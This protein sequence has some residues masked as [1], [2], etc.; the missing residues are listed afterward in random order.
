VT[1]NITYRITGFQDQP[2]P[3]KGTQGAIASPI[4]TSL[5]DWIYNLDPTMPTYAYNTEKLKFDLGKERTDGSFVYLL[6]SHELA[7]RVREK[8]DAFVKANPQ[9]GTP[10]KVMDYMEK[11]NPSCG[12]MIREL[13]NNQVMS[14]RPSSGVLQFYFPK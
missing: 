9:W 3:A 10:E 4:A 8:I 12:K 11:I 13:Y 6:K 14:T 2:N 1:E 7:S 5:K